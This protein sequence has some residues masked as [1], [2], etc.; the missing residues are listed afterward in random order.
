MIMIISAGEYFLP[1]WVQILIGVAAAVVAGGIIWKKVIRPVAKLITLLD[2]VLPLLSELAEQF[3]DSPHAFKVLNDIIREF[4]TDSGS[5]L[6][7]VINRLERA[8]NENKVAAGVLKVEAETARRL[9]EE[10]R[11][12][13]E[14]LVQSLNTIDAKQRQSSSAVD[15]IEAGGKIVAQ[16]L[17][18][19]QT[20]AEKVQGE[21]GEA[22]D[23]AVRRTPGDK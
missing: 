21:P 14:R 13:L 19:A 20:R 2:T 6:R 17:D 11:K 1:I 22:A 23:A 8:A 7:D 5:T 10:D 3:K 12:Q 18:A 16:E 4:R 9:A 15:R